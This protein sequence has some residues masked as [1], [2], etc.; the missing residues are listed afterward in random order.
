MKEDYSLNYES[1]EKEIKLENMYFGIT[2]KIH[3]KDIYSQVY[4][5]K[6]NE[7]M[8]FIFWKEDLYLRVQKKAGTRAIYLDITKNK[9]IGEDY[10]YSKEIFIEPLKLYLSDENYMDIVSVKQFKN[11]YDK[12]KAFNIYLYCNRENKKEDFQVYYLLKHLKCNDK[13]YAFLLKDEYPLNEEEFNKK[14]KNFPRS[15]KF[16]TPYA[17]DLHYSDYFD[18][19]RYY[20]NKKEFEYFRDKL[21]NRENFSNLLNSLSLNNIYILFG[22]GGIGK[23]ITIIQVFKYN[24]D[25]S[26]FG[27][28]YINCKC[29][30][31]A[32][33]NN[34]NK[35]KK[36]LKDEAMFLFKDEYKKYLEC[37]DIIEKY[38]PNEILSSFWDLIHNIINLCKNK[39]KEYY[40]IFDQYKNKIDKNDELFK[41]NEELKT[42]NQFCIIAC[43]SLNDKDVRFYKLKKLFDI[44]DNIK[45][46]DNIKIIEVDHLLDEFNISLDSGGKFDEA[47]KLIGKNIKNYLALSEIKLSNPDKLNEFL[48]ERKNNIK[49]KIF[50]FYNIKD[51]KDKELTFINNLFKF[52]V[53]TEYEMGY[54]FKIQEYIPFKY[55]DVIKNKKDENY[56]EIIYNF[57]LVREVLS[58]IYEFLILNNGSIYKIF[59]N[60][61]LLD[62]GALGG[63]FEKYVIYNMKPKKDGRRNNI[64]GKFEIG[65][66]YE[67]K[68]FV[69]NNNENWK[70][71]SYKIESLKPG[72]YLFKQKN[73]NGKGFD[74]AIIVINDKNEATIYLF[75]ISINKEKIY[76]KEYLE[77]LIDIFIQYFAL[78]FTFSINKERVYFTYIFDIKHKDDLLKKCEDNNMKCIFFK[79][80]IK[81]FT[82]KDGINLEKLNFTED[83]FVC[84]KENNLY[85]RE[86]EMK[87]LIQVHCQH[88]YLNKFQLNNLVKILNEK[89]GEQEKIDIIFVNNTNKINDLF[90]IKEGIL[91]RNILKSE[92]N[93]WKDNIEGGKIK[94][95]SLIKKNKKNKFIEY[96]EEEEEEN[97]GEECNKIKIRNNFILLIIKES[98]LEFH[99]IFLSGDIIAIE[100]LPLKNQGKKIYD[101]FYIERL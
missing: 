36:I 29:I 49:T 38:K 74:A 47:F 51:E 17:F 43:C 84:I 26:K 79:P 44:S 83:I 100:K 48:D 18:F 45:K 89:S 95:K 15:N 2:N 97:E 40:I 73:F 99:L 63:L 13:I 69:P 86:I 72:T 35:M 33:K 27:T 6:N 82:D 12:Y 21:E 67:V 4:K 85:G 9:N 34:I 66:E 80:T 20:E 78:L 75:Q 59:T 10:L 7:D 41:L 37:I 65:Y 32:F 31:K 96:E 71:Q 94:Y 57:E 93:E 58:D 98:I 81:L 88:V 11:I 24:Y 70:N 25:H 14:F 46:T 76:T 42:K 22:K 52:S 56:A 16:E 61:Q 3:L 60:E 1:Y 77:K 54:L 19:Y 87:N 101:L 8:K 62:E 50:D 53:G 92:L 55:F 5:L 23:S 64:F 91:M 90:D 30:Y 68:K 28:L 39:N